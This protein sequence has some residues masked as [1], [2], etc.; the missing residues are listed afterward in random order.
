L[1]VTKYFSYEVGDTCSALSVASNDLNNSIVVYPN[2]VKNNLLISS[3]TA[4]ITKVQIYSVVGKL[5]KQKTENL[6]SI[7]VEDLSNG[8]YLI[9]IYTSNTFITKKFLKE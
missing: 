4:K 9:K 1:A 5:V 8:L 3:K 6:N 2:P 7:H